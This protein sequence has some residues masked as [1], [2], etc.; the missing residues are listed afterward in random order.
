M[1]S[2]GASA[3]LNRRRTPPVAAFTSVISPT[4]S[5]NPVNIALDHHVSSELNTLH[6]LQVMERE[7]RRA[8][9]PRHAVVTKNAGR[10]EDLNSIHDAGDPRRRMKGR[11]SFQDQGTDPQAGKSGKGVRDE[12][13]T[14]V[15]DEL[16]L[17]ARSDQRL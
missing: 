4:D 11:P 2:S 8:I 10:P 1:P 16:D 15:A 5:I 9:Q 12:R 6:V 7:L 13:A 3:V 14:R 17:R